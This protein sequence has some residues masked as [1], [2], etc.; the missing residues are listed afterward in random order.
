MDA[1]ISILGI[2]GDWPS[3]SAVFPGRGESLTPLPPDPHAERGGELIGDPLKCLPCGGPHDA[4][5]VLPHIDVL[6]Q[7]EPAGVM[8]AGPME[9]NTG[10]SP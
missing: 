6:V 10:R 5:R 2:S 9:V 8:C 4:P 7:H 3:V 1:T